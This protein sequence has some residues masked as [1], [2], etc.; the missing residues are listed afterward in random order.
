[1]LDQLSPQR[2][3][4]VIGAAA[5]VV[6]LAG[7]LT[8]GAV[9]RRGT[10]LRDVPDGQVPVVVVPGYGGDAGSVATLADRLRSLGRPVHVV[11]LPAAGTGTVA[12]S[13]GGLQRAVEALGVDRVDLVGHSAGG[14]VIRYWAARLDDD[15]VARRIVTLGSPHHGTTLAADLG[16]LSPA[17]CRGA[18]AELRPGSQ[19]LRDLNSGDETPGGAAWTAVWTSGDQTVTPPESAVLDGAANVRVQDVCPGAR[20]SHGGLV[21][22]PLPVALTLAAVDGRAATA[23]C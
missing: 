11:E 5:L 14:V 4:F 7:G 21:R 12:A 19:V 2:R 18:C 17:D 6:L 8:A 9:A 10:P 20:V 13:A 16:G 22:D 23:S 15:D 3:R 1:M